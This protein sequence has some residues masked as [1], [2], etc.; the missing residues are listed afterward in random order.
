MTAFDHVVAAEQ[1][2]ERAISTAKE[3]LAASIAAAQATQK[4]TIEAT[5]TKLAT[6]TEQEKQNDLKHIA[7]LVTKIEIEVKAQ[8][9]SVEQKFAAQTTALRQRLLSKFQ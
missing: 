9:A 8:V 6:A 3:E 1:E 5:T 4:T 2:A 7:E